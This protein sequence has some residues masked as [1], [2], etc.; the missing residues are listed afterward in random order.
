MYLFKRLLV[1]LALQL[2]ILS[3][4]SIIFVFNFNLEREA[5]KKQSKQFTELIAKQAGSFYSENKKN[6]NPKDFLIFIDKSIGID[7]LASSFAITRPNII[8]IYLVK[9][10][11]SGL[12]KAGVDKNYQKD[13][14]ADINRDTKFFFNN[15]YV[16][17]KPFYI[18]NQ[19][20]PYGIVRVEID[21]IPL[22]FRTLSTN[23][24][25]Y[26][27]LFLILNNQAFLF[28]LWTK[29]KRPA[30]SDL[31]YIKES[32]IGS[33]KIMQKILNQI[34]DDHDKDKRNK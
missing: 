30:G 6:F 4:I 28:Y 29:K 32:S 19:D 10:I 8:S 31:E 3:F 16:A 5:L 23:A 12:V 7:E 24:V 22:F 2:V 27:L 1:I 18:N 17:I 14:K 25:F 15:K 11:D 13:D 26:L 21:N 34:I 9:D 33:I 20:K